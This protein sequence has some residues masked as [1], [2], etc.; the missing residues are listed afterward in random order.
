MDIKE[1]ALPLGAAIVSGAA[2]AYLTPRIASAIVKPADMPKYW[3]APTAVG[4][5][6]GTGLLAAGMMRSQNDA[7][8]NVLAVGGAAMVGM[9][10]G[11]GFVAYNAHVAAA[12]AAAAAAPQVA[13]GNLGGYN[14]Q[15]AGNLANQASFPGLT[16][17]QRYYAQRG[18]M[19]V[20]S[21]G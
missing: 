19:P 7:L 13:A 2:T 21:G 3:Y 5:A 20:R 6:L 8:A 9:A 11:M 16:P 14:W 1:L 18:G 4:V 12:H 15:V 17:T 10:G